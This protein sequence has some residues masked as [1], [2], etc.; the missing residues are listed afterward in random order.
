MA[1]SLTTN[2]RVSL[3]CTHTN[4]LDLATATNNLTKLF[5][6]SLANG[7]ASDQSD[8]LF[9]DTRSLAATSEDLDL[10]GS[11]TDAFGSTVTFADVTGIFIQ[12]NNTTAG[13]DLA[14]G[15]AAANQFINW[16]SDA[17]DE[18]VVRAGGCLLLWAPKDGYAVTAATGDLLKIDAGANTVS[19]DIVLVGTS[20]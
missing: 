20:S 18:I 16:V 14:I 3:A 2:L 4:G 13:H 19:Y 5:T 6:D 11:L 17:S 10:A 8:V 9:H 15:G 7:T 1:T 12:N